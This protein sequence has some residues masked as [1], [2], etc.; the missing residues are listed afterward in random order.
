M[1][2]V[3]VSDTHRDFRALY[4]L[5][6]RQKEC[7]DLF[8][9]LG[10]GEREVED[11]LQLMPE[12]PLRY[13]QGNCDL[14][15]QAPDRDLVP[16]G[17]VKLFMTHG[18]LHHVKHSL[19]ELIWEARALHAAVALYGHT[20]CPDYRYE[21]GLHIL[22]PGSLSQPRGSSRSYGVIEIHGKQALCS[23]APF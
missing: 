2:I 6:Q 7:T 5:V 18:H 8:L 16:A 12:L 1:R 21:D 9:H 4:E 3:V 22:N 15:S 17:E 10:D 14:C 13:V 19:A 11:L 23:L 20:H